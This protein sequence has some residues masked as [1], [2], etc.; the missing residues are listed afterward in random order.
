MVFLGG[1][2]WAF[3]R[4]GW[5]PLAFWPSLGFP[6]R[7]FL[8]SV[9]RCLFQSIFDWFSIP[10]CLQKPT[11]INQKSMPRGT[12]SWTP[13]FDRFLIDFWSIFRPPEPQKSLKFYWFYKYFCKIGLSKLT[14]IFDPIL[15]PTCLHFPSQNPPKSFQKPSPGAINFL[16]DFWMDFLSILAPTWDPTWGQVGAMLAT[17][18][19]QDASKTL[20]RRVRVQE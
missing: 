17:F 18:P 3:D 1:P 6:W 19:A 9:F 20:P 15:V 13:F 7:L 5:P 16:I 4:L 11:K 10:T 8:A 14:S 12:P 2:L